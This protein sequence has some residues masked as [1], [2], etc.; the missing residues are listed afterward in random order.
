MACWQGC[1]KCRRI[2][3]LEYGWGIPSSW[4]DWHWFLFVALDSLS[5]GASSFMHVNGCITWLKDPYQ[6]CTASSDCLRVPHLVPQVLW[7]SQN[8]L[9][10]VFRANLSGAALLH[11]SFRPLSPHNLILD[12]V[13]HHPYLSICEMSVHLPD[14]SLAYHARIPVPL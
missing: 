8:K 14:L 10:K 13:I 6:L 3:C 12:L 2:K 1:S 11:L 4:F 9:I 7:T 5:S